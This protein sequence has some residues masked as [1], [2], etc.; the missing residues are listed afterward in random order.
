M[1]PQA[2]MKAALAKFPIPSKEIEVY[3]SQIVITCWSRGAAEKWAHAVSKF[4]TFRGIVET[5]DDC[6][7]NKKTCLNPSSVKVWRTFAA[8]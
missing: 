1:N 6:K 4:A 7:E 2:E 3:G 8:V 5:F